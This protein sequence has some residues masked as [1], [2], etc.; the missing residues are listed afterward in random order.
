[1]D[2]RGLIAIIVT[3]HE[4]ALVLGALAFAFVGL[5]SLLVFYKQVPWKRNALALVFGAGCGLL[6]YGVA[7][8]IAAVQPIDVEIVRTGP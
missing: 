5:V 4:I 3:V 7:A 6:T 2:A 1:M 8:R